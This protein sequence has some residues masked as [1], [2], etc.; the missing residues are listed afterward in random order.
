MH[1]NGTNMALDAGTSLVRLTS[2]GAGI[3]NV[4]G[5]GLFFND[6]VFEST[7]TGTVTIYNLNGGFN[8]LTFNGTGTNNLRYSNTVNK[9]I[10]NGAGNIYDNNNTIINTVV[11]NGDGWIRS[12]ATT[13]NNI[14][15]HMTMNGNGTI[16]GSNTF[17][18]LIFTPGFQYTF[19]HS[20]TQTINDD[21]VA[22]GTETEL[23][24][25]NSS[26]SGSQA[27]LSKSGGTVTI[28]WVTLRDN[29]ATGGATFIA[30]NTVDLGNNTGW[31]ITAPPGKDYYWVGGTG[32]W[33]NA[34]NWSLTSGGAGGAGIPTI[35]D[36]VFFD[37]NSFSEAGQVVTLLGD[38]ANNINC[39]NMD[40]TGALFNPSIA[41][42]ASRKLRINGSLT[43]IAGM[44]WDFLGEIY[45]ESAEG[46]NTLT[47]AG[48]AL[49]KNHI[50]FQNEDGAWTLVDELN[51][52]TRTLY[53]VSGSLN[54][55]NQTVNAGVFNSN[56]T[57][58]RELIF[59]SS[60]IVISSTSDRAMHFNG[61]NMALDAATSAVAVFS[62]TM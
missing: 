57:S 59:G 4:S 18:T 53:L 58:I 28:E 11:F 34:A 40:W 13:T 49:D 46:G 19:Q 5:G 21:L 32:D 47:S 1:F 16:N 27:T 10:F 30:N 7:G 17:G 15:T 44:S 54:T 56:Y 22:D 37:A 33:E 39:Y 14:F 25:I 38:A 45:F 12:T 60:E 55:N 48:V 61:T 52:G 24:I 31:N 23:I 43:L 42:I 9:L 3:Y 36:N 62:S 2:N 20:R 29:E 51:L 41:G 8:N 50:Y 6:V 26:A 35:L